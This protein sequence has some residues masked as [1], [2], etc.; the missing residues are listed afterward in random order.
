M[1][2]LLV[3][4][5][6]WEKQALVLP[7][8]DDDLRLLQI[9]LAFLYDA[10][11]T[12]VA[13]GRTCPGPYWRARPSVQEAM[14]KLP[15]RTGSKRARFDLTEDSSLECRRYGPGTGKM[16]FERCYVGPPRTEPSDGEDTRR[17]L[18]ENCGQILR[19]DRQMGFL[20]KE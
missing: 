2:G 5:E 18:C 12:R 14:G 4:L 3:Q 15:G 11:A 17:T 7:Q 8:N 10:V 20:P 6:E 19:R 16:G 13:Q 1:Q 9:R